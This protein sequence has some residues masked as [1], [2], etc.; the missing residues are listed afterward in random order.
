MLKKRVGRNFL[1]RIQMLQIIREKIVPN[2]WEEAKKL[3]IP[4]VTGSPPASWWKSDEDRD[5][6]LGI[7]KHGYQQ[8]LSIRSDPE[9][10]FYGK[11]YDDSQT[12]GGED[13]EP[14]NDQA[15]ETEEK[16]PITFGTK[17]EDSDYEDKNNGNETDEEEYIDGSKSEVYIWPSKADIGM[18]LRRIIAAFLRERV[19]TTRRRRARDGSTRSR[20]RQPAQKQRSQGTG[21]RS[22]K[23]KVDVEQDE[24][25]KGLITE[26]SVEQ[27]NEQS[28]ENNNE[29]LPLDD[30]SLEKRPETL[31]G[32]QVGA[33]LAGNVEEAAMTERHLLT[34]EKEP[35]QVYTK[36]LNTTEVPL[37]G[38]IE[39]P[40]SE[41]KE[42]TVHLGLKE[43]PVTTLA[44]EPSPVDQNVA[45]INTKEQEEV[46][47][48]AVS[49]TNVLN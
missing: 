20:Q 3:E 16:K 36:E 28:V 46:A 15:L 26:Q 19:T 37:M 1:L 24:E 5:L 27:S 41:K 9:F 13:D 23:R 4:R 48:E 14:K 8:Y 44:T 31:S 22:K 35:P 49:T 6:L 42:E 7:L 10:C 17:D 29:L 45:H 11:K 30:T 12:D 39:Q 40:L 25:I 21:R 43:G 38:T 33:C 32:Y 34:S 18:R 47:S 2:D